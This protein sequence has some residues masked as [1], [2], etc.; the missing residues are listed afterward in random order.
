MKRITTLLAAVAIAMAAFAGP[1][2]NKTAALAAK[3]FMT[4]RT[5]STC[6]ASLTDLSSRWQFSHLYLFLPGNGGFVITAADD[7]A[8]PILAYSLSGSFNPDAIPASLLPILEQYDSEIAAARRA[9]APA[10]PEW[11][12]LLAGKWPAGGPSGRKDGLPDSV[13]PLVQTQWFQMSPYNNLCP[14]GCMTG[15][16][17]TAAAQLMRYWAF[18]AF[19]KGSHSYSSDAGYGVLT[20]DFAHTHYD[21]DN[22]PA[23]VTTASPEVQQNAVATLMYHV[24][25]SVQMGYNTFQ[26][27]AVAGDHNGDTNAYCSQNALW[28]FF[29]YNRQD[30]NYQYKGSM[31]NDQWTDLLINELAQLRPV[32]YNGRGGSGGH[33]FICDGYDSRRYLHFNL[34]EDGDGDGF[35]A[36]GAISY[37]SYNFNQEN[38]CVMGIHPDYTI[39]VSDPTVSFDRTGGTKTIWLATNDTSDAAWTASCSADWLH[40]AG[41]DFQH[42]G[43]VSV[44]ADDNTSGAERTATIS[45]SQLGR[46]A[47]VTVTQGAWSE[48]DY[49]PLTVVMECTRNGSSWAND[50]HLSFESP[51]GQVYG[52]AA[53]TS[54]SRFSTATVNV[55]PGTLLIRYHRGGP[56]DRYYN[57]WVLDPQG[58]TLV[59]VVNAY[60]NGNDVSIGNPCHRLGIDDD[61]VA[62]PS[63]AVF[64]NPTSGPLLIDHPDVIRADVFDIMG[65]AL[66]SFERSNH[67]DV[68]PLPKG[69]YLLRIAT[70]EGISTKSFIRK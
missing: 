30:I 49:C 46:T 58:D 34:G 25:V 1:V 38:N 53:H 35:Y 43:Q 55:A 47:T 4:L 60:Y 37:G 63:I 54:T 67:V 41:T 65:R 32:L 62:A 59:A 70:A 2:D 24:G 23:R 51:S 52:T 28:R 50:A 7:A 45:F 17:A 19:G 61:A 15:C 56:Q 44:S 29:R 64:P 27:G 11:E 57:Y 14:S 5:G 48:N 26:S 36:V 40:L 42:L 39:Y 6:S 18:P 10:D 8:R 31:D 68:T 9:K 3:N 33:A 13:G 12:Q 21:W 66:L 69:I 16:V 22:M 20:A